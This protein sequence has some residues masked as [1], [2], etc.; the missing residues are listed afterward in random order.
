MFISFRLGK[1]SGASKK[2]LPLRFTL[3]PRKRKLQTLFQVEPQSQSSLAEHS[4]ATELDN[5]QNLI[6]EVKNK[7]I[8]SLYQI[9]ILSQIDHENSI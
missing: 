5:E 8:Q 7:K 3:P 1:T 2:K 4:H 6:L 9:G